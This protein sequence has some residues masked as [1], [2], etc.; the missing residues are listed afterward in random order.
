LRILLLSPHADDIE[1]GCGGTVAKF[2]ELKNEFSW[3]VFSQ[4][5]QQKLEMLDAI[6]ELGLDRSSCRY[7]DYKPRNLPNHRQEILDCLMSVKVAFKPELIIGPSLNDFHQDHQ[8]IANEMVRAF[9][10]DCSIISYELPWNHISFNTQLFIRLDETHIEKKLR[11]VECYKSQ[12]IE[13]RKFFSKD[14]IYS[15]ASVR[16]TQSDSKFSE[17]FEVIRWMI[18]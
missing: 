8:T 9:K 7:L 14:Y 18:N 16:G 4:F 15:I 17:A 13:G 11:A 6:G 12:I 1:I 3:I 5:E 2:N 10:R